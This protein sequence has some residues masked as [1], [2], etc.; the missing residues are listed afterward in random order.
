MLMNLLTYHHSP[1]KVS[2]LII[3]IVRYW[4]ITE[5]ENFGYIKMDFNNY[6]IPYPNFQPAHWMKY[7]HF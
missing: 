2:L 3:I 4:G 1:L 7:A 5:F 6:N